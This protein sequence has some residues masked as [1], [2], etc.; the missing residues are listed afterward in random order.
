MTCR[1]GHPARHPDFEP[2]NTA[3]LKHGANSPRR[4]AELA[5]EVREV[6]AEHHPWTLQPQFADAVERYAASVVVEQLLTW[7]I[8]EAAE[9]GGMAAS[10]VFEQRTAA[11]RL[12]H[13]LAADL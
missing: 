4:V 3:A 13:Q 10:R 6:L 11:T 5:A 7:H 1:D 12:S 2:G 9:T 8:L